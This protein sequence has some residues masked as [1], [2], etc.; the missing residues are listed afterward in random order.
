MLG[1]LGSF[2]IGTSASDVAKDGIC[3]ADPN[4]RAI[5]DP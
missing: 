4:A 1:V 2:D 5:L 3:C